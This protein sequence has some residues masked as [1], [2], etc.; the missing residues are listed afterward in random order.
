VVPEIAVHDVLVLWLAEKIGEWNSRAVSPGS[1]LRRPSG[2]FQANEDQNWALP[3]GS[4]YIMTASK[5][6]MKQISG[7]GSADIQCGEVVASI[8]VAATG[9][10]AAVGLSAHRVMPTA[11]DEVTFEIGGERRSIGLD[12]GDVRSHERHASSVRATR[13]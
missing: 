9:G 6:E 7:P 1:L 12:K 3:E 8:E 11:N 5:R 10:S 4:G 13:E 2:A